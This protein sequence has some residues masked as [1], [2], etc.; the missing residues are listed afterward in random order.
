MIY[1]VPLQSGAHH[2]KTPRIEETPSNRPITELD[3]FRKRQALSRALV[4]KGLASDDV[5]KLS[6]AWQRGKLVLNKGSA[7]YKSMP[8]EKSL[9]GRSSLF[10]RREVRTVLAAPSLPSASHFK[11]Y[12][13][14]DKCRA[15]FR[16]IDDLPAC[17]CIGH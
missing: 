6:N 8:G 10:L 5:T 9:A 2:G 14:S 15:V 7:P 13:G 11:R 3:I 12:W 17:F 16:S 4:V 1:S